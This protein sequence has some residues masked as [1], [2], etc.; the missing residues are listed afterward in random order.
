MSTTIKSENIT[1]INIIIDKALSDIANTT[2]TPTIDV[3]DIL[4]DIKNL[5]N[6]EV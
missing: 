5:I 4:L 3:M 2:I 1:L 6:E